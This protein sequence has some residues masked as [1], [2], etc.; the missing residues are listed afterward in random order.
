MEAWPRDEARGER[1]LLL[2]ELTALVLWLLAAILAVDVVFILAVIERRLRRN[3]FFR[4]KDAAREHYRPHV[5]AFAQRATTPA[6]AV[7]A[8]NPA[9]TPAAHAA[10]EEL[11]LELARGDDVA[12]VTGLLFALR[13]V[14][15]WAARAFG[16]RRGRELIYRF[17]HR[18]R[19]ARPR[20]RRHRWLLQVLRLRLFAV[21]RALAVDQLGRLSPAYAVVFCAEALDDPAAEVR[22]SAINALAA[23]GD[24]QALPLLLE[25]LRKAVEERNDVSLRTTR[26]AVVACRP[27]E[28]CAL[29]PLLE[30]ERPRMRF[31]V[32]DT[33]RELLNRPEAPPPPPPDACGGRFWPAMLES[34]SDPFE[35]VRARSS[36]VLRHLRTEEG[37]QAL[38]RLLSDDNEFVRLHAVRA[39]AAAGDPRLIPDVALRLF[40]SYWRVREAA[41]RALLQPALAGESELYDCFLRSQDQYAN[42]QIA[43]ELQRAGAVRKLVRALAACDENAPL[44][45]V[46]CRKL[47]ELGR[48]AQLRSALLDPTTPPPA[49]IA[50]MDALMARP[51]APVLRALQALTRS[52]QM[53]VAATA[54][55]L[56]QSAAAPEQ[57]PV[58]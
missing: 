53:E 29:L 2:E 39:S 28:P 4:Q 36:A 5:Q 50:L 25:E 3:R 21:P 11:L 37:R 46:V 54:R 26:A 15:R 49:R 45:R 33:I 1:L 52:E 51:T 32:V 56:L 12:R 23:T 17:R 20:A 10:I 41:A 19:R 9:G 22:R 40:D 30:E 13:Y 58:S 38:R 27:R 42:E 24:G 8:L 18:E 6:Q 44:A 43:E 35:D 34:A 48:T 16:R 57:V 14:D 31:L 55:L 47:A 7:A